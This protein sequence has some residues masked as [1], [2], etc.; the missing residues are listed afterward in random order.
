M[1]EH[2]TPASYVLSGLSMDPAKSR[3]LGK[4]DFTALGQVMVLAQPHRLTGGEFEMFPL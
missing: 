4:V 2:C 1:M 3:G